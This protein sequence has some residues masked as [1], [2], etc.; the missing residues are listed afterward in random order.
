M[1]IHTKGLG[2]HVHNN[3]ETVQTDLQPIKDKQ[4][5]QAKA[6]SVVLKGSVFTLP[7]VKLSST[8][9][10]R[11]ETDLIQRLETAL[12][13][14]KNAPVVVDLQL[15]H[16]LSPDLRFDQLDAVLRKHQL[17]PVGIQNGSDT[18]NQA[19][20]KAGWAIL[21]SQSIDR[22][23]E[24][25]NHPPEAEHSAQK[26]KEE[27][28]SPQEQ[29]ASARGAATVFLSDESKMIRQPIRSGQRVYAK[30]GDLV[31]LGAVNAGAEVMADGNIHIYAP[32]RGRALAGL[33]GNTEA[34]IFCYS[35]EA[36][37]VAV[38]GNYRVF[39]ENIPESVHRKPAQIYLDGE[40][41]RIDCIL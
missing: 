28:Q 18:Q 37:L 25:R 14:F 41:L 29:A 36:E 12:D 6:S 13:F 4:N 19:A 23:V 5:D 2:S 31:L 16:A 20:A 40:Q 22:I 3:M 1:G 7:I 27:E 34:R 17:V 30:G 8:D 32:L 10:Q 15:T 9:L 39:E 24:P 26:T 35:M 33:D 11:I 21:T 38:A